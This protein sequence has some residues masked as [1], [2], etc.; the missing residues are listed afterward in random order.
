MQILLRQQQNTSNR[1]KVTRGL[2]KK[3]VV[4]FLLLRFLTCHRG[5]EVVGGNPAGP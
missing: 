1:L 3:S 5:Q 4:E 2:A